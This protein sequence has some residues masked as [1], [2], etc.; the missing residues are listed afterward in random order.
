MKKRKSKKCI[1]I[2]AETQVTL[3][4]GDCFFN[5][6]CAVNTYLRIE[7]RKNGVTIDLFNN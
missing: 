4:A 2:L 3:Q 5:I 1:C 7:E 6:A